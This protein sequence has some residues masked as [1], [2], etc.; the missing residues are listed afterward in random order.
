[1]NHE[2]QELYYTGHKKKH[3]VKCVFVF[4]ADGCILWFCSNCPGS[5]HDSLVAQYGGLYNL[6]QQTIPP[7]KLLLADSA[8]QRMAGI[9][10]TSDRRTLTGVSTEQAIILR[11]ASKVVSKARI[12]VEWSIG[13]LKKTFRIL[14][15]KLPGKAAHRALVFHV[16]FALW[17][18]RVRTTHCS[19]VAKVFSL[20]E[21]LVVYP[22][23]PAQ[24]YNF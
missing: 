23:D 6:I 8:F 15:Q 3:A 1:M 18:L 14:E 20:D 13:G 19:E 16:C 5:W 22:H 21:P 17:N 7:G 10:C 9:L 11:A 24:Q 12:L 2:E 4:G